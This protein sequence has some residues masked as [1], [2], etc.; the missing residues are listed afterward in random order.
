MNRTPGATPSGAAPS[1]RPLLWLM[2]LYFG[3]HL[4]SRV[5]VSD[6]L[7]LDEAE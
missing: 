7:E 5:L 4:A 3:A 6:A 2:L 1:A